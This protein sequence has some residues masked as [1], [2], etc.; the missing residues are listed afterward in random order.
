M[1]FLGITLPGV[2]R[3]EKKSNKIA[4]CNSKVSSRRVEEDWIASFEL[5]E[6]L[7]KR[8]PLNGRFLSNWSSQGGGLIVRFL[9]NSAAR[10][11]ND[12]LVLGL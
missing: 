1:N 2:S 11:N 12:D 4:L 8:R 3:R 7:M 10:L 5:T 9:S 6:E